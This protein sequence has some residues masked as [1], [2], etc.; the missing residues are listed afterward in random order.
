MYVWSGYLR[1]LLCIGVRPEGETECRVSILCIRKRIFVAKRKNVRN[2]VCISRHI[3]MIQRLKFIFV[4]VITIGLFVLCGASSTRSF[5][6]L[7]VSFAMTLSLSLSLCPFICSYFKSGPP[8][9]FPE[10]LYLFYEKVVKNRTCRVLFWVSTCVY[11]L[12]PFAVHKVGSNAKRC[13]NPAWGGLWVNCW[14]LYYGNPVNYIC[15]SLYTVAVAFS[16]EIDRS[17]LSYHVQ[18]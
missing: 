10:I 3:C 9:T 2:S 12:V 4:K 7:P 6:N 17:S 11:F 8:L 16:L 15:S 1:S 13:R 18:N 14:H 5:R